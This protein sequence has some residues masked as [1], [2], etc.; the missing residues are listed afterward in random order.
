MP[1]SI[2]KTDG[3]Y[4]ALINYAKCLSVC[5]LVHWDTFA[6]IRSEH[7]DSN[8]KFSV[9]DTAEHVA[10]SSRAWF[11]SEGEQGFHGYEY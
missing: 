2:I 9:P 5:S 11:V 4:S 1:S 6:F 7:C 10:S 8:L 3:K